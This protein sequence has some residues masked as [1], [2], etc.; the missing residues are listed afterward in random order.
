MS[1]IAV[2]SVGKPVAKRHHKP[3][4]LKKMAIGPFSQGCVELRY[5]ADI[6]QFDALDDALIALQVE[7][8]W[9]IFVA[10]F[11]ERYHVAVTFI[12]G[13]ASQQAVID[14]VQGV[15]TQVHGDVAELKVLAGDANYG[16]WDASYD[17]Q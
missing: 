8:G 11:N 7:Q 16:D 13:D 5:Q 14:A 4:H 9:D 12:E 17:A 15:I 6:D 1:I 3:R 10:Y 2:P